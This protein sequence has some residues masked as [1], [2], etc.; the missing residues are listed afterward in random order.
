MICSTDYINRVSHLAM[1]GAS[2]PTPFESRYAVLSR[3]AYWNCLPWP[4]LQSV[5]ARRESNWKTRSLYHE[6]TIREGMLNSAVGWNWRSMEAK[7]SGMRE[8]YMASVWEPGFRF[9]P[10]CLESGLHYIWFQFAPLK[11]CPIHGCLL[12]THCQSCGHATDSY[13]LSG[14]LFSRPYQC[15]ACASALCG[16]KLN[17]EDYHL[18][19]GRDEPRIDEFEELSRWA[20]H[21][22]SHFGIF[23]TFARRLLKGEFVPRPS[24]RVLLLAA[25]TREMPL[26]QCCTRPSSGKLTVLRWRETSSREGAIVFGNQTC[27]SKAHLDQAHQIYRATLRRLRHAIAKRS[28]FSEPVDPFDFTCTVDDQKVCREVVAYFWMRFMFERQ[29]TWRF[30]WHSPIEPL[31]KEPLG[32]GFVWSRLP[33]RYVRAIVMATYVAVLS[34]IRTRP[35]CD[36]LKGLARRSIE[37]LIFIAVSEDSQSARGA[38]IFPSVD[39]LGIVD[40]WRG[41]TDV[42]A[43]FERLKAGRARDEVHLMPLVCESSER[44][45]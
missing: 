45:E 38:V 15:A 19:R 21:G 42:H 16:A 32:V 31:D 34:V 1:V 18:C 35:S 39:W 23:R 43:A 2:P 17:L 7:L 10:I 3:I 14:S 26:P 41:I 40:G 24:G 37:D 13:A 4:E 20:L 28:G 44:N 22:Y 25:M 29:R 36:Y 12:A 11:V 27:H 33:R 8:V 6:V 5:A 30:T 9:C